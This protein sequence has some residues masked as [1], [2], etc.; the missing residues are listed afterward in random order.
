MGRFFRK[1]CLVFLLV[2]FFALGLGRV[3]HHHAEGRG[4]QET[5][6]FCLGS[7]PQQAFSGF[8]FLCDSDPDFFAVSSCFVPSS[9]EPL[10][11]PCFLP[12][13]RAPPFFS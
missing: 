2:V 1:I 9:T 7:S 11:Q 10:G 13:G 6:Q 12:L 4:L 8:S 3:F 5:C